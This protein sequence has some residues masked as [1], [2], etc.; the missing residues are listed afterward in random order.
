MGSLFENSGLLFV[1]LG[2]GVCA[3]D[4]VVIDSERGPCGY[5]GLGR[6]DTGTDGTAWRPLLLCL[7]GFGTLFL[8]R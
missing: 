6:G 8:R 1:C 3:P 2:R 7:L 5:K 4:D